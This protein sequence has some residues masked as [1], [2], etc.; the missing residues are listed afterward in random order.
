MFGDKVLHRILANGQRSC[1]GI[2][3]PRI[4]AFYGVSMAG[5]IGAKGKI[6]WSDLCFKG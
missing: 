3:R 6:V 5:S 4:P 2:R 1:I